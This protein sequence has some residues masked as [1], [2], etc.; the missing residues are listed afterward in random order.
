[1]WRITD[2]RQAI[3]WFFKKGTS[4]LCYPY[5]LTRPMAIIKQ[6]KIVTSGR[7]YIHSSI[8]I[9]SITHHLKLKQEYYAT[10]AIAGGSGLAYSVEKGTNIVTE[11]GQLIMDELV[12]AH[13][14][15]AQF[16][17]KGFKYLEC[18]QRFVPPDKARG[19]NVHH[20]STFITPPTI[21]P[22][23]AVMQCR[24]G[25]LP[26]SIWTSLA[27]VSQTRT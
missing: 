9:C 6:Q 4:M 7:V 8:L 24:E 3:A 27:Y 1:M 13:P 11:A 16:C 12:K 25:S 18:M 19:T 21:S 17:S 2:P 23:P 14:Q 22:H 10:S 26:T 5:Y 15:A 20:A